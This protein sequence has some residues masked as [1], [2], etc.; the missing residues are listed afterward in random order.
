MGTKGGAKGR[1]SGRRR[2][3]LEPLMQELDGLLAELDRQGLEFLIEQA[4][5]LVH[6]RQVDRVNREMQKLEQLDRRLTGRGQAREEIPAPV[7]VEEGAGHFILAA[8]GKRKILAT[9]EMRALVKVSWSTEEAGEGAARLYGWLARN[10]SDVL[11]DLGASD[12]HDP[13]LSS[14]YELLRSRYRPRGG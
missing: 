12:R 5:V 8:A 4:R 7:E 3:E 13:L 10:R 9:E 14:L 6:N 11:A 2:Q 1:P